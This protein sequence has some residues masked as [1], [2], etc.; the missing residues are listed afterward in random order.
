[1]DKPTRKTFSQDELRSHLLRLRQEGAPERDFAIRIDA[2]GRWY[3]QG[4]IIGRKALVRTLAALLLRLDDGSHWLVN[5]AEY[6]RI[7]VEDV[8]FVASR[9]MASG[10]GLG[11]V[12]RMTTNLEEACALDADHPLTVRQGAN[13]DEPRP[14]VRVRGWLEARVDR[15]GYYDLVESGVERNGVVGVWSSGEFFPLGPAAESGGA[16]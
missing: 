12:I 1:M 8:P 15:Q 5:P 2:D 14:Y 10:T 16:A 9:V 13:P 11:Q 7:E 4:G 6:G 3:H